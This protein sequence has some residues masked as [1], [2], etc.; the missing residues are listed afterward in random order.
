MGSGTSSLSLLTIV[1]MK[2]DALA[3][4]RTT[5]LLLTAR[6]TGQ[7]QTASI[8][9]NLASAYAV[10]AAVGETL[11][12]FKDGAPRYWKS[13][14]ASR[15][16]AL[17]H[18]PLPS[19]GIH[20]S[21][22]DLRQAPFHFRG[23]EA[24]IAL[25]IGEPIDV[26]RAA[27]DR[28][29]FVDAMCVAIEVVDSRWSAGMEAAPLVKLADLQ[30][31][32]ALVLGEWIPFVARDWTVQCGRVEIGSIV[33]QFNGTHALDDPAWGLTTWMRHAASQGL[34]IPAGTVVTTGTWCGLRMAEPGDS[35]LVSFEGI[36]EVSVRF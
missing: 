22:A 34:L 33:H 2:Y 30:S 31:H 29:P 14:G 3:V 16:T 20:A 28:P 4:S 32:G 17:T 15:D 5:N 36:G 8:L 26:T 6:L 21:P 1:G 24:E 25:R 23:I 7:A 35:V 12:W 18:A 11:G 13:G 27:I 9:P 10:Q 19:A